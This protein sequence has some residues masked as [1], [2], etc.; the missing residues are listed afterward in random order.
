MEH[1]RP[2]LV[3]EP[4]QGAAGPAGLRELIL[5]D[6]PAPGSP[7]SSLTMLPHFLSP[8][9]CHSGRLQSIEAQVCKTLLLL[10]LSGMHFPHVHT[11]LT[12]SLPWN[13]SLKCHLL[14]NH[15]FKITT[16]PRPRHLTLNASP[17][18]LLCF[19]PSS[20]HLL[21]RWGPAPREDTSAETETKQLE[22]SEL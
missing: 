11:W 13:R 1:P 16:L 12:P 8:T 20:H 5:G 19:L 3:Q 18:A 15:P 2:A 10:N 14:N 22:T 7:S 17:P 9:L 21:T 6:S 4:L